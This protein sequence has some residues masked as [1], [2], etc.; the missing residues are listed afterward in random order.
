LSSC[1]A[2]L[3]RRKSSCKLMRRKSFCCT[4]SCSIRRMQY[5]D[6]SSFSFPAL[7]SLFWCVHSFAHELAQVVT[8]HDDEAGFKRRY[9]AFIESVKQENSVTDLLLDSKVRL[10][11]VPEYFEPLQVPTPHLHFPGA[12]DCVP[13]ITGPR[14]KFGHYAPRFWSSQELRPRARGAA[15]R[16]ELYLRSSRNLQRCCCRLGQQKKGQRLK[17]LR[18]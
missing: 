10:L 1:M 6:F 12:S 13:G 2:R 4:G 9:Q 11:P 15:A 14:A 7:L 5:V 17:K 16:G 18:G 8:N 3:M